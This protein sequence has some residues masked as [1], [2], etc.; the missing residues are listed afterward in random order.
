MVELGVELRWS[1]LAEVILNYYGL[2][3]EY[4][5]LD[6]DLPNVKDRSDVQGILSWLP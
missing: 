1:H 3:V 2:K 4:V 6:A 5:P